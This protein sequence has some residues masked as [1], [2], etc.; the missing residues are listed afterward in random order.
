MEILEI[1]IK[2]LVVPVTGVWFVDAHS[3][4]MHAYKDTQVSSESII[5]RGQ[6]YQSTRSNRTLGYQC[7]YPWVHLINHRNLAILID[8]CTIV[9][10]VAKLCLM[11]RHLRNSK[12]HHTLSVVRKFLALVHRIWCINFKD[13]LKN[14]EEWKVVLCQ[15]RQIQSLWKLNQLRIEFHS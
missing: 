6:S 7:F 13:V 11:Q 9:A 3:A 2:V 1:H 15:F 12:S 5:S 8:L 4:V 10:S 14:F